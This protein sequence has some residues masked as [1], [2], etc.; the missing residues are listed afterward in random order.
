MD[1]LCVDQENVNY[2]FPTYYAASLGDKKALLSVNHHGSVVR[3]AGSPF[4]IDDLQNDVWR[5]SLNGDSFL[6]E[7]YTFTR[8]V[9][10]ERKHFWGLRSDDEGLQRL[11]GDEI[12]DYAS[13]F[14]SQGNFHGDVSVISNETVDSRFRSLERPKDL[15]G[16]TILAPN[17][18]LLGFRPSRA[19]SPK[20]S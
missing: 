9:S 13:Q 18:Y 10:E 16:T 11:C 19:T 7:P 1:F 2:T 8:S 5:V 20:S 4:R 14:F 15:S 6:V 17:S 3:V 12:F